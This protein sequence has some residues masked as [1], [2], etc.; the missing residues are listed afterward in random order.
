MLRFQFLASEH[1]TGV[2]NEGNP[3]S[4]FREIVIR[5]LTQGRH[6]EGTRVI[7]ALQIENNMK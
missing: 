1:L 5:T 2:Y 7:E 6:T 3:M 4:I